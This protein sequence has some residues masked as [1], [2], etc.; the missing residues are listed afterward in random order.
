MRR[1]MTLVELLVVLAIIA[2]LI[3]LL[4][5]AVQAVRGRALEV[6][7]ANRLKQIN[8]ATAHFAST[9]DGVLPGPAAFEAA[10]YKSKEPLVLILPYLEQAALY[11]AFTGNP[12]ALLDAPKGGV[13]LYF[14]PLDPT[15]AAPGSP[16]Y[17][18]GVNVRSSVADNLC[19]FNDQPT[20]DMPDGNS[21]TILY[22][23]HYSICGSTEFLFPEYGRSGFA[24]RFIGQASPYTAPL[25]EAFQYRPTA[26]QCDPRLPQAAGRSGMGCAMADGSVRVFS[27]S[28]DRVVFWAAVTPAGGEVASDL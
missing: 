28:T 4:L 9:N 3:G 17:G 7:H 26:T 15:R 27:P 25:P 13:G 24:G 5:P 23:E 10:G 19:V 18:G 6:M 11:D 1:G 20:L 22:A 14:N 2:L 16:G 21:N 12:A 8:L